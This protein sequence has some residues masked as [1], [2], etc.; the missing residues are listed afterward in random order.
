MKRRAFLHMSLAAA[1]T[2][3]AGVAAADEAGPKAGEL[4]E[5]RVYSLPAAKQPALDRYLGEARPASLG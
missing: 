3:A 2:T 4:Y 1:G 5:L